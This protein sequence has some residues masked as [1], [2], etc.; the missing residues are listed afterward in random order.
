MRYVIILPLLLAALSL[1]V[2]FWTDRN[3]D[4]WLSFA[5]GEP[6]DCPFILSWAASVFG[7]ISIGANLVGELVR[8]AI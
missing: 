6:V 4:F 8:L 3:L 5:K 1:P 2:A 7:P